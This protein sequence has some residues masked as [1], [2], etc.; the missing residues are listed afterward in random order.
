M[1]GTQMQRINLGQVH[2][3]IDLERDLDTN[4]CWTARNWH[5]NHSEQCLNAHLFTE[6]TMISKYVI[7]KI[8]RLLL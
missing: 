8:K 4:S 5:M 3:Q 1:F 6:L 2:T 7:K